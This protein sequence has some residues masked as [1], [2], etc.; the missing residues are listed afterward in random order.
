VACPTSGARRRLTR[1]DAIAVKH[2]RC[3]APRR[4]IAIAGAIESKPALR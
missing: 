4:R 2:T 1:L 3:S